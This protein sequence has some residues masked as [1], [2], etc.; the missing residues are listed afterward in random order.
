MANEKSG[1]EEN[2]KNGQGEII[3]INISEHKIT[4]S[5]NYEYQVDESVD[6][7]KV[8]TGRY[9]MT[10]RPTDN[11]YTILSIQV[12]TPSVGQEGNG[13]ARESRE[14]SSDNG[15]MAGNS[16]NATQ[17]NQRPPNGNSKKSEQEMWAE[18]DRRTNR[19]ICL[20]YAQEAF[21]GT[22]NENNVVE[23]FRL[24]NVFTEFVWYGATPEVMEKAKAY[25]AT[26]AQKRQV[27]RS[28]SSSP[29][30]AGGGPT[31]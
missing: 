11:G 15:A 8:Q 22:L 16:G 7:T 18:K 29:S 17:S 31:Q 23:T 4:L 1:Q 6:L 27:A 5:N 10:Y 21:K 26:M 3:K 24:A 25:D 28:T 9:P 30:R 2:I 13:S 19:S 14:N 20:K 12:D